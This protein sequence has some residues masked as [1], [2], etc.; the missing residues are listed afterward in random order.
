MCIVHSTVLNYAK[1]ISKKWTNENK[2]KRSVAE[3]TDR[4]GRELS[5]CTF[6]CI[7][8]NKG[9]QTIF[10]SEL[11]MVFNKS[12]ELTLN[13]SNSTS[14]PQF[15]FKEGTKNS[16]SV[17][18]NIICTGKIP[19]ISLLLK[20]YASGCLPSFES[21][22]SEECLQNITTESTMHWDASS[23]ACQQH[24]TTTDIIVLQ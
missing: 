11:G 17:E 13:N 23:L 20:R 18:F 16:C 8:Y 6:V 19:F 21:P 10:N 12:P 7:T 5:P 15:T 14:K 24:K 9:C 3:K 1:I 4:K 2:W 22:P